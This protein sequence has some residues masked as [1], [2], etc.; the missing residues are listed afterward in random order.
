[1]LSFDEYSCIYKRKQLCGHF[2]ARN[3]LLFFF[4]AMAVLL[5]FHTDVMTELTTRLLAYLLSRSVVVVCCEGAV[6]NKESPTWM[7]LARVCMLCNRAEFRAGQENV[8]VLKRSLQQSL[9]N[10]LVHKL[11]RMVT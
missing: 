9:V 3:L 4:T 7:A 5:L 6:Y 1:V 8:P 11:A 2:V 10:H